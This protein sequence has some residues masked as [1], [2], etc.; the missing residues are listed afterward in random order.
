MSRETIAGMPRLPGAL[1]GY[2][3][4]LVRRAYIQAMEAAHATLPPPNHT[5]DVLILALLD[6]RG[7]LSQQQLAELT[8]VNRTIIVKLID[9]L[10][11]RG[12][13]T[14]ARNPADRRSY[15]LQPTAA[16]RAALRALQ[17]A[18]DRGEERF[19]AG[20]SAAERGRLNQLLGSLLA[21]AGGYLV[22]SLLNRTGYLVNRAHYWLR[23]RAVEA[24]AP[25]SVDP[26]HF[27]VL[28]ILDSRQPCSQQ[29]LAGELGISA[30]AALELVDELERDGLVRRT[31]NSTDRR[32]Y[33]LQLTDEGQERLGAAREAVASIST[34]LVARLGRTAD[35]ELRELLAKLLRN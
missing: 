5:R 14:R 31:R 6:E 18:V 15:A 24:L 26:R 25:L 21:D 3:G 2:T 28:A 35:R 23:G 9:G 27:G 29:Q 30:P 34:E 7:P 32:A 22:E 12:F 33:D 17:P 19:T 1:T 16:G 20:L 10:E 13:V 4:F 11:D 8:G